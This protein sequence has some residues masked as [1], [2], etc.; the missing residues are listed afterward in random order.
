MKIKVI[1][2]LWQGRV[3]DK[4]K[5]P[6]PYEQFMDVTTAAILIDDWIF[7]KRVRYETNS[8]V[9]IIGYA[10]FGKVMLGR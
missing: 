7:L 6:G 3:P 4:N 1:T 10:A 8:D 5:L 9:K 2:M